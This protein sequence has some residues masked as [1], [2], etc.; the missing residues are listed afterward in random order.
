MIEQYDQKAFHLAAETQRDNIVMAARH[1]NKSNWKAAVAAIFEI[2]CINKI[3]E[4]QNADFVEVL[5]LK[6]KESALKAFLYRAIRFYQTFS[7]SAM[8]T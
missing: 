8:S 7:I 5:T 1:L 3:P 2:K 6:F 4:F